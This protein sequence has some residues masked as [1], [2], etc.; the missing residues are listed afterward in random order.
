MTLAA[1]VFCFDLFPNPSANKRK[2]GALLEGGGTCALQPTLRAAVGAAPLSPVPGGG[3]Q[4]RAEL[5]QGGKPCWAR[6]GIRDSIILLYLMT[7][8]KI[9]IIIMHNK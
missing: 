7:E 3:W 2:R 6:W 1:F 4:R 5:P 8:Y 9:I